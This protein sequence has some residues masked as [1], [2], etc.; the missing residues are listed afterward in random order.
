MENIKTHSGKLE[1]LRLY[2]YN[3]LELERLLRTKK[4][5]EK[6]IGDLQAFIKEHFPNEKTGSLQLDYDYLKMIL[7]WSLPRITTLKDL[8]SKDFIFLWVKPELNDTP[9]NEQINYIAEV[10]KLLRN[11]DTSIN[12]TDVN[13]KL[14]VLCEEKSFKFSSLMKLLRKILSG[15]KVN[16]LTILLIF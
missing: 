16:S 8:L 13:N 3:R 4:E 6:L 11:D 7:N 10:I 15:L 2:D 9:T 12:K 5:E 14:K 1:P